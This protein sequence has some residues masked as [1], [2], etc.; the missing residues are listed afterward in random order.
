M[1]ALAW[2][3]PKLAILKGAALNLALVLSV[4]YFLRGTAIVVALAG[5]AGLPGWT[6]VASAVV[7]TVLVVPL[8]LLV[9]GIWTLGVFD[10]W[11]TFR[12]RHANRSTIR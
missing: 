10:T 4:L 9:P 12:Q 11:L 2:L 7:A 1:A 3:V 8:L 5:A 6:L